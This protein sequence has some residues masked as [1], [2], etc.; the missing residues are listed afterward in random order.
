[1]IESIRAK[2]WRS[3]KD[4]LI[5]LSEKITAICGDSDSGKTALL[6]ALNQVVTN[7]PV[8]DRFVDDIKEASQVIL[9][10]DGKEVERGRRAGKTG[11]AYYRIGKEFFEALRTDVPPEVRELLNIDQVNS[12]G[13]LEQHFMLQ[14]TSTKAGKLLSQLAGFDDMF[15]LLDEISSIQNEA[16]AEKRA[17]ENEITRLE[18][19]I[20]VLE[21]VVPLLKTGLEIKVTAESLDK[22]QDEIE[23]LRNLISVIV[24]AEKEL[25][26][27]ETIEEFTSFIDDL[28]DFIRKSEEAEDLIECVLE[29]TDAESSMV[30]E[31]DL[32]EYRRTVERLSTLLDNIT[33]ADD[34]LIVIDTIDELEV[35]RVDTED[36]LK[37]AI[38]RLAVAE[39]K[40]RKAWKKIGNCP[41][42]GQTLTDKAIESLIS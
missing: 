13:Q 36:D 10:V 2:N 20:E 25:V 38:N 8:G 42:C 29:I 26:S 4:T 24:K 39:D 7:S 27:K 35:S 30:P 23:A 5:E 37:K 41:S 22:D 28:E 18:N 6:H 31:I 34:L 32:E 1:M 9:T 21:P 17:T 40:L 15:K 12:Q 33:V 14:M 11:K 16:R 3:H 19:N